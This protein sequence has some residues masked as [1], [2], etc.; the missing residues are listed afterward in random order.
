MCSLPSIVMPVFWDWW[1]SVT[2]YHSPMLLVSEKLH[3]MCGRRGKFS[4]VFSATVDHH[5][6]FVGK[7]MSLLFSADEESVPFCLYTAVGNNLSFVSCVCAAL[8][9]GGSGESSSTFQNPK[10]SARAG[11]EKSSPA[12]PVRGTVNRAQQVPAVARRM[13]KAEHGRRKKESGWQLLFCLFTFGAYIGWLNA[14]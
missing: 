11:A 13:R 12:S 7:L 1:A 14:F 5:V 10:Y 2:R 8:Q 4:S 3:S 9:P 6:F